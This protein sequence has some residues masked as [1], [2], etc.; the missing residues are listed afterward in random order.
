[1]IELNPEDLEEIERVATEYTAAFRAAD[2]DKALALTMLPL[3]DCIDLGMR[4]AVF[5]M[6]HEDFTHSVL[7]HAHED[8]KTE[9]KSIIIEPLGKNAALARI[10]A[11]LT[12]PDG[13]TGE[14]EWVDFLARTDEGWKIWANWLGPLPEGF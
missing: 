7:E 10:E 6:D 9:T 5:L 13:A 8:F 4:A 14:T 11:V 3:V 12:R 1:M 2:A